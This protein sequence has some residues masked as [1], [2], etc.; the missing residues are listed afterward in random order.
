MTATVSST[1]GSCTAE[2]EVT[3]IVHQLPAA[4]D[5]TPSTTLICE[6]NQITF[7]A[8]VDPE[9]TGYIW[10]QNGIEIPGENQ[11]EITINFNEAGQYTFAAKAISIEGCISAEASTPVTVT[12]NPA[13]S[14]VTITGVNVLCEN[15]Q[16][17]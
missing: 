10:Y 8:P 9:V 17:T 4:F 6:G 1:N 14:Q 12:V 11:N 16:T 15:D 7:T 5:V 3:I 2:G 13:P